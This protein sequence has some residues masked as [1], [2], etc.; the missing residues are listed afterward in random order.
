M[1]PFEMGKASAFLLK[2]RKVEEKSERRSIQR[3][4]RDI[5]EILR[6]APLDSMRFLEEMMTGYGF[7]LVTL[8]SFDVK[9]IAPG[10]RVYLLVRL[11]NAECPL[12]DSNRLVERM[13]TKENKAK[14]GRASEAKIWF[15]QIWLMHLDLIYTALDR[16][17]LERNLWLEATFTEEKLAQAVLE[18][19]N[20]Y[21]RRLNP[22]ECEQSDVYQ[23]LIAEKG[24]DRTR[25]VKRFL[26]IMVDAGM[27]EEVGQNTYR[28]SLLS[29]VEMKANYERVLGPLML[30]I[31][32]ESARTGLAHVAAT[33]L[34]TNQ[35]PSER[36]R[37]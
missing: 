21:V 3:E 8:S 24:S 9:G 29:A 12:L 22:Q 30:D 37:Q 17:P 1:T 25:Y 31:P 20:G 2:H 34:T 16:G 28:Q 15:T 35:E 19:I 11:S 27:L 32:T 26:S 6:E 36:G 4:E 14:E 7:D 18:H 13:S 33:L 5:A 10:S 23:T